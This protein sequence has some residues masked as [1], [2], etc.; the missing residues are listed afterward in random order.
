MQPLT[1]RSER[2]LAARDKID[3]QLESTKG[4]DF[5]KRMMDTLPG[6]QLQTEAILTDDADIEQ[7]CMCV[8]SQLTVQM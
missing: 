4:V 8:E 5:V 6:R 1:L 7:S 2:I 3:L